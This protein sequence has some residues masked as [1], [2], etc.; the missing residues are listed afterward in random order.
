PA[1]GGPLHPSQHEAS[2]AAAAVERRAPSPARRHDTRRLVWS[3]PIGRESSAVRQPG[4]IP[5]GPR[6]EASPGLPALCYSSA[7][8]AERPV[9]SSEIR[10]AFLEFF[11]SREHEI[12]PSGPLVPPND[13]SLYFANSGMVQFKDVFTGREQRPYRRAA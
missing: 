6:R 10:R 12:V 7:A 13:P 1:L 3:D 4:Q 11:R 8:M 5:S 9:R 2:A